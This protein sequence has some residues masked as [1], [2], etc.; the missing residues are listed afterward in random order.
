MFIRASGRKADVKWRGIKQGR[1]LKNGLDARPGT[2]VI[3]PARA[4]VCNVPAGCRNLIWKQPTIAKENGR[5]R[6][7]ALPWICYSV[8]YPKVVY[9]GP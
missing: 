3:L 9:L 1:F 6:R 5:A 4:D 7:Q 8:I 2:A